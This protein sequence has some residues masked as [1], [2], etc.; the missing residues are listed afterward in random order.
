M[1]KYLLLAITVGLGMLVYVGCGG[2]S[3]PTTIGGPKAAK[4]TAG[5]GSVKLRTGACNNFQ[6]FDSMCGL[7]A[8]GPFGCNN[9]DYVAT[10]DCGTDKCWDG[11]ACTSTV[12]VGGCDAVGPCKSM[13]SEATCTSGACRICEWAD[14]VCQ[15]KVA[16]TDAECN[17]YTAESACMGPTEGS[18]VTGCKWCPPPL[19]GSTKLPGQCVLSASVCPI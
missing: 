11:S 15:L 13:A 12:T 7:A 6:D 5:G 8:V 14:G 1:K 19:T 10:C 9:P 4:C 16:T 18:V 17:T 2:G 3:T